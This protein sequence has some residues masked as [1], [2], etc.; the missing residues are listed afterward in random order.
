MD[1]SNVDATIFNDK[2]VRNLSNPGRTFDQARLKWDAPLDGAHLL[3]YEITGPGAEPFRTRALEYTATGLT[4]GIPYQ[5]NVQA[6]RSQGAPASPVSITV[7]TQ[8][9]V[10][11]TRPLALQFNLSTP[12]HASLSWRVSQDNVGVVYY[13]LRRNAGAWVQVPDAHYPLGSLEL[14]DKFDVRT[15]DGAGNRSKI[16]SIEY[17]EMVGP[18]KPVNLRPINLAWTSLTL[19]WDGGL[20]DIFEVFCN[21]EWVQTT[22]EP[23]A[24]ITG[25]NDATIYTFKVRAVNERGDF[26]KSEPLRLETPEIPGPSKPTN[27]EII[28]FNDSKVL[29][30]KASTDEVGGLF[31]EVYRGIEK[32]DTTTLTMLVLSGLK[33]GTTYTFKVRAVNSAKKYTDSDP[34]SYTHPD[35]TAPSKPTNLTTSDVSGTSVTL[36]W[37]AASDN[38]GVIGYEIYHQGNRVDIVETTRTVF[39]KMTNGNNAFKVRALDAAGNGTDSDTVTL[40]IDAQPPSKP[41]NLR[42]MPYQDKYYLVWDHSTDNVG[43]INYSI[44]RGAEL[45]DTVSGETYFCTFDVVPGKWSVTVR[46]IDAAGNYTDSDPFPVTGPEDPTGPPTNL[47]FNRMSGTV[48]TM[49]WEPPIDSSGVT[50]YEI[51]REGTPVREL[52]ELYFMFTDLKPGTTYLFEVR[53]IRGAVYS[54]PASISG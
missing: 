4:P 11:P 49:Q 14:N 12:G 53:A 10:P 36:E 38:V 20:S 9:R 1:S 29:F 15:V 41:S 13:E 31:Y 39:T 42:G 34:L 37:T 24:D 28:T 33:E 19:L 2:Q 48:G 16:T 50:G 7:V 45:L 26:V 32:L 21:D 44:Y 22:R 54:N 27:L 51:R 47:Q 40:N 17:K 35:L 25:L 52:L 3:D 30:W 23:R 6:L 8:D 5:F 43:V 46:A 18:L